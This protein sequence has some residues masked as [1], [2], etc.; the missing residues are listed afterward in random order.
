M[1]Y[2]KQTE[3]V[4]WEKAEETYVMVHPKTKQSLQIEP[5]AFMIWAQCDG[6]TSIEDIIDVFAVG[7]NKEV[8]KASINGILKRLEDAKL[9]KWV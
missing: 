8:V 2:P 9:I 6:R 3:N 1:R 4:A 5:L 7:G